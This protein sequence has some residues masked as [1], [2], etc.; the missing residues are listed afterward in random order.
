MVAGLPDRVD[1]KVGAPFRLA[2]AP[3]F[4]MFRH[5]APGGLLDELRFAHA[6][7]FRAWEDN[8]MMARPICASSDL[9]S[10]AS[11]GLPRSG[12]LERWP[13]EPDAMT[14]PA[15]ASRTDNCRR[16]IDITRYRTAFLKQS[17][18]G[19]WQVQDAGSTN[20][21]GVNG[22]P[23]PRQGHGEPVTVKAGDNV[24][25]GQ[26]EVTFLGANEM[27]SFALEIER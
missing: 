21:T 9:E 27:R 24:R 25:L 3:H 14:N 16:K 26:I 20:G 8:G 17:D 4:G 1:A 5:S 13:Y 2:Y 23:V 10:I 7:G 6:Q 11:A 15:T 22:E 19:D 18:D 12:R